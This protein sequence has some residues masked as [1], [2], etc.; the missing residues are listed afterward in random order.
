MGAK[1]LVGGAPA[2]LHQP[3]V[4][5]KEWRSAQVGQQCLGS[6]T[7]AREMAVTKTK[8]TCSLGWNSSFTSH[9][10]ARAPPRKP[11]RQVCEATARAMH[12]HGPLFRCEEEESR[13]NHGRNGME[14]LG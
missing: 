12:L 1:M 6:S 3:R 5:P 10:G 9:L 4:T 13:E 14:N 11:L 8:E 2:V 7:C